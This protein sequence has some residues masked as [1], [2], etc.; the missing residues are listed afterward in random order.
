MDKTER[1]YFP[2]PAEIELR[3]DGED[4]TPKI[5]GYA[6]KFF[7]EG[8]HGTEFRLAPDMFERVMPGA[9]DGAMSR[10]DDVRGML[11]H[12]PSDLLGRT[13][14]GTMRLSVD[15]VG[16]AFDLDP[17][18]TR[19][20]LDAVEYVGRGDIDGASFGFLLDEDGD[21]FHREGDIV[22]R[23]LRNVRLLDVSLVTFPAYE[24][25]S[26]SISRSR[27]ENYE[28]QKLRNRERLE[29]QLREVS[30]RPVIFDIRPSAT[31]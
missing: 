24:A 11:N 17:P 27:F 15:D 26:A 31:P 30:L 21:E 13:S 16:L 10:P 2:V 23:E 9:F 8:D 29:R 5:V 12:N 19:S 1:I 18:Q 28:S 7:R 22:V 14:A 4:K 20:G 6:A 25:T 3:Q